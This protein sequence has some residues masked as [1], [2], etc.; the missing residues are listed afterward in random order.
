MPILRLKRHEIER[1]LAAG[2]NPEA[3]AM[4]VFFHD[5]VYDPLRSDNE[6]LSAKVTITR[7]TTRGTPQALSVEEVLCG[8][9][10]T[11]TIFKIIVSKN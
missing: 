8:C 7:D 6:A 4:A 11:R 3:V 2:A 10:K 5:A 1:F 9:R